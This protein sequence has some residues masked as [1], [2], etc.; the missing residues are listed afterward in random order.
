M[1][2]ASRPPWLSIECCWPAEPRGAVAG[3]R[4]R[5]KTHVK[6]GQRRRCTRALR[7]LTRREALDLEYA[8]GQATFIHICVEWGE[9]RCKARA[10]SSLTPECECKQWTST[11]EELLASFT[12][13]SRC[14]RSQRDLEWMGGMSSCTNTAL[15]SPEP[16][17][18]ACHSS[19]WKLC[20]RTEGSWRW[21]RMRSTTCA[22]S[23][24]PWQSLIKSLPLGALSHL[25]EGE[26]TIP[27]AINPGVVYQSPRWRV[28][29]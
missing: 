2:P 29:E 16:G 3:W 18:R 8:S 5:Q 12:T 20:H 7:L 13:G 28:R 15:K 25:Y 6:E 14:R 27:S 22:L 19:H 4:A 24:T 26:L 1:P 17:L 11:R 21:P 10:R 23:S 9:G